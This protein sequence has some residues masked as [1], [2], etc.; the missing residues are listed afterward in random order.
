MPTAQLSSTA[1]HTAANLPPKSEYPEKSGK[2]LQTLCPKNPG[3]VHHLHHS[4][5]LVQ[6]SD[7]PHSLDDIAGA[8]LLGTRGKPI[9]R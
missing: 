7:V 5:L 8:G 6:R 1:S 3:L 2:K 4:H 9:G